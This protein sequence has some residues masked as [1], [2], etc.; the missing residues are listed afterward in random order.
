MTVDVDTIYPGFDKVLPNVDY[1]VS[2]SE[3]PAGWTGEQDHFKALEIDPE[4][5]RDASGGDDARR[6]R[7]PGAGGWQVRLFARL[8]S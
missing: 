4:A 1:L 5:V 6:R 2:S 3:F 8:S 7:S